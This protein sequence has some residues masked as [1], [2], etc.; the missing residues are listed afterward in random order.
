MVQSLLLISHTSDCQSIEAKLTAAGFTILHAATFH[1]VKTAITQSDA[2]LLHLPPPA[3][4]G[5]C[6]DLRSL[7]NIPLL[8]WCDDQEPHGT[9][10]LDADVDGILFPTMSPS[11]I[12]WSYLV[13]KNQQ[14]QRAQLQREREHL[15]LRLEERKWIDQAKGILCELKNI[16]EEEAYDFLRK[17]A[18]NERKRMV[19]VARSMVK[20]YQLIREQ[21]DGKG[22]KKR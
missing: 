7:S 12:Q 11:E 15:L 1:D 22:K 16:S 14:F 4:A 6:R 18:M 10:L 5:W 2:T 3:L 17:Q 8:W 19:D 21:D 20:V 9:K 13:S